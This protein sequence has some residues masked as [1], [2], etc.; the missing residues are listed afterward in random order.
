MTSTPITTL[1]SSVVKKRFSISFD[2]FTLQPRTLHAAEKF[3]AADLS[4][5]FDRKAVNA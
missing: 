3:V 2:P 5:S 1:I 4:P